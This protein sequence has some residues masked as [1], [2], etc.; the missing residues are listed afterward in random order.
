VAAL[1]AGEVSLDAAITALMSRPAR[2]EV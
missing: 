1:V 2:T